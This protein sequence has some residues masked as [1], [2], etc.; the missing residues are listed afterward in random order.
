MVEQ[1]PKEHLR[2]KVIEPYAEAATHPTRKNSWLARGIIFKWRYMDGMNQHDMIYC[3]VT[4]TQ[5]P[6]RQARTQTHNAGK[7]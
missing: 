1:L 3:F 2:S 4:V 6:P 5:A 7:E